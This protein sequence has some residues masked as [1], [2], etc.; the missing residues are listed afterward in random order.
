MPMRPKRFISLLLALALFFGLAFGL[1]APPKADAHQGY[2]SVYPTSTGTQYFFPDFYVSAHATH[3]I[4]QTYPDNR[5]CYHRIYDRNTGTLLLAG[6]VTGN[7]SSNPDASYFG[8]TNNTSASRPYRHS[9]AG[10]LG[11]VQV[12]YWHG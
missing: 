10:C 8:F 11:Q 3:W 1:H 7:N 12:Y 2:Y 6:W 9:V 4:Q 5:Q